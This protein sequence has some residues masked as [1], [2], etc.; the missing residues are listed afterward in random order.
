LQNLEWEAQQKAKEQAKQNQTAASML[1]NRVGAAVPEP[2]KLQVRLSPPLLNYEKAADDITRRHQLLLAAALQI[3]N[4][5]PGISEEDL[6]ELFLPFGNINYLKVVRNPLGQS[7]GRKYA[8]ITFQSLS[9]VAIF[10]E[11]T[12]ACVDSY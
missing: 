6:K 3:L 7:T 12:H 1:L 10:L 9:S 5:H 2:I 11:S 8:N 4:L